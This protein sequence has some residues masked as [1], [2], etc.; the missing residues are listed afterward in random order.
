MVWSYRPIHTDRSNYRPTDRPTRPTD[1][2]TQRPTDATISFGQ[3]TDRPTDRDRALCNAYILLRGVGGNGRSPD[4]IFYHHTQNN[5]IYN[6]NIMRINTCTIII[7]FTITVIFHLIVAV[8]HITM[9]N[10]SIVFMTSNIILLFIVFPIFHSP[11]SAQFLLPPPEKHPIHV[12]TRFPGKQVPGLRA[13][14]AAIYST[15]RH[16]GAAGT[17]FRL[18]IK[19]NYYICYLIQKQVPGTVVCCQMLCFAVHAGLVPGTCFPGKRVPT[20]LGCFPGRENRN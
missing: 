19:D 7:T 4:K 14:C 1:R 16:P 11:V 8:I 17:R 10:G 13:R 15:W 5:I 18:R 2:P 20:C 6:M 9:H 12:G 3:A